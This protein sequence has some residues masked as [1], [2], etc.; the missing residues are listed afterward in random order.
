MGQYLE[1]F[2]KSRNQIVKRP[3][4]VDYTFCGDV[5]LFLFFAQLLSNVLTD[6]KRRV[7][8]KTRSKSFGQPLQI[9]L[10]IILY[11]HNQFVV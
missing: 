5:Y 9:Q 8:L 3:I 11:E 2:F 1:P 4:G 10:I 6:K 7:L